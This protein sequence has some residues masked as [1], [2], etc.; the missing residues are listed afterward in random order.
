LPGSATSAHSLADA[1]ANRDHAAIVE[2][3]R[4]LGGQRIGHLYGPFQK[5]LFAVYSILG[6]WK[7][8]E[9][10]QLAGLFHAAYSTHGFADAVLR[11][12][13]RPWLAGLIG[14]DA[15]QDA[16]LFC[17]VDRDATWPQIG[18]AVPVVFHD[19]FTGTRYA[20]GDRELCSH[21]EILAANHVDFARSDPFRPDD[22][23]SRIAA[24][25]DQISPY[26][27]ST[28]ID[29]YRSEVVG[30]VQST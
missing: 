18:R 6:E 20:V 23:V 17:A 27:S 10:V 8:P 15:E 26:L 14:A 25:L 30:S 16:Y 12:E 5:H 21:C 11:L 28:A 22:Q 13:D 24:L 19:R 1:A 7:A 3:L 29:C 4:R 9:P 2:A